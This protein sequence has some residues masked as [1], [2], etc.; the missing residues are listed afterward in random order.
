MLQLPGLEEGGVSALALNG[1]KKPV[2]ELRL[3]NDPSCNVRIAS[4]EETGVQSVKGIASLT[5]RAIVKT[6]PYQPQKC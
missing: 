3:Q 2:G 4:G 1:E 5:V 6:L